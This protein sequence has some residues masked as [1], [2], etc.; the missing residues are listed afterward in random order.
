MIETAPPSKQAVV[1][2]F[3]AFEGTNPTEIR[4]RVLRLVDLYDAVVAIGKSI[5][6]EASKISA[7]D[8]ILK[9][10]QLYPG[11]IISYKELMIIS[12]ISEWARRVRELRVQ[13]GWKIVTAHSLKDM[14]A[15][16][17]TIPFLG[18]ELADPNDYVLIDT[19]QDREAAFRWNTANSIRR[20]NLS[21]KDAILEF[22]KLNVGKPVSG[23]ELRYVANEATEWA[24]RV[25][26]LRTEQGWPIA[27]HMSGR[28]D[29]VVGEYVLESGIPGIIH[30]RYIPDEIRASVLERD[31]YKC[32]RCGWSR[33]AWTAAE[34]RF[35]ELHHKKQHV[36]GGE[37]TSE[38]LETLCNKCHDAVPRP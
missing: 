29:L 18:L 12:A 31:K 38:N 14:M 32:V 26:E 30:D 33:E 10:L 21:V 23:E 36:D 13:Y 6:P 25:R 1:E 24:R 2:L 34:P 28:P 37:N 27:T 5:L 4:E 11:I 17:E 20:K 22:L 35:L 16:G 7:R 8:R 19:K 9:Y 3:A 15:E